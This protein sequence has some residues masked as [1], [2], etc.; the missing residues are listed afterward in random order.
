MTNDDRNAFMLSLTELSA[1]YSTTELDIASFNA[2]WLALGD[3]ALSD[4]KTAVMEVARSC[5]FMP[6]PAEIRSR[7][8]AK[9]AD[10]ERE[11]KLRLK[12]SHD[13][14]SGLAYQIVRAG[15][16]AKA[17]EERIKEEL[18]RV[19]EEYGLVLFWPGEAPWERVEHP[20]EPEP[21]KLT[22]ETTEE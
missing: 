22:F 21:L 20:A 13:Q 19:G 8:V 14:A 9:V 18:R 7:I 1:V 17:S 2:Y 6:T 5:K 16:K 10:E 15:V 3:L 11:K 4:F 12:R